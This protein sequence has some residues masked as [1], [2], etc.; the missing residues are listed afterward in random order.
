EELEA[1]SYSV[2]HDLKTP[3]R[4]ILSFLELIRRKID[5]GA[6]AELGQY[7]QY[8]LDAAADMGLIIEDLLHFSRV[9]KQTLQKK[10]L[11]VKGLIEGVLWELAT[12]Q[13]NRQVAIE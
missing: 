7:F 10:P 4:H 9:S 12:E 8:V 2:S 6:D 3:L 1:F 5:V 11:D 13:H